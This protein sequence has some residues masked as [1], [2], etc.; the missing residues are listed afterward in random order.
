[1]DNNE[2]PNI[3]INEIGYGYNETAL[4][5]LSSVALR[6]GPMT[7]DPC[8]VSANC[9]EGEAWDKE[10]KGICHTVQKIGDKNFLCSG[11][12]VNNTAEGF[13][14][15]ILTARHCACVG[16]IV[17]DSPD[18]L[19]WRFYFHYT[20]EG[21]SRTSAP[22][23]PK[24]LTGCRLVFAS[25]PESGSDGTLLL[26]NDTIPE[27]YL[28]YNGWDC[29]EISYK[30]VACLHHPMSDYMEISTCRQPAGSATFDA[31]TFS[32]E[33]DAHWELIFVATENRHGVVQEGSSG[34]PLFNEKK[35]IVGTLTGQ[36]SSCASPAW[37]NLFGKM[38][39]HRNRYKIEGDSV[40]SM[41]SWLDPLNRNVQSLRGLSRNDYRPAPTD[42]YVYN[43]GNNMNLTWKRPQ[44]QVV[45]VAGWHVRFLR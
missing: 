14:P 21:C 1:M 2:R 32:C 31:G 35:Q 28:Y 43:V 4:A 15:Y 18:M 10:M 5:R 33:E 12:L 36:Y 42:L 17:A 39:Y 13:K 29:H 11:S 45:C 34:S 20:K 25:G 16:N 6:S 26:L 9:S 24:S 44:N 7:S 3:K 40:T 30:S 37:P 8:M 23:E 41:D 22:V 19:Q 38:S 27:N